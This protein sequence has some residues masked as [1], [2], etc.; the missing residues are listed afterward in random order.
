MIYLD[1]ERTI[2]KSRLAI[3]VTAN[4]KN[5]KTTSEAS[6]QEIGGVNFLYNQA[7]FHRLDEVMTVKKESLLEKQ[8]LKQVRV[9]R[10]HR[11]TILCSTYIYWF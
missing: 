1:F 6:V 9:T 11:L 3:A 2:P 8:V 10:S 5:R 4:F 7:F